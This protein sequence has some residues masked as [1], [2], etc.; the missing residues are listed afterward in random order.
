VRVV[1]LKSL[2]YWRNDW[3]R[4]VNIVHFAWM[5]H[6]RGVQLVRAGVVPAPDVVW[7]FSVPLLAPWAAQRLAARYRAAFVLEVGDLWPQTLIDMGVLGERHPLTA[8]LRAIERTL[9]RVHPAVR[10]S[11]RP[12]ERPGHAA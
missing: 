12:G 8:F 3:R 11:P 2:P 6:R 4:A 1:W 9:R 10:R 7:A 5:L